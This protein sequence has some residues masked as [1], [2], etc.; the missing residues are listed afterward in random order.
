MIVAL[1]DIGQPERN[2]YMDRSA[3]VFKLHALISVAL[4][5]K[6][7]WAYLGWENMGHKL[8][9][10]VLGWGYMGLKM[11]IMELLIR[12]NLI[13]L[14]LIYFDWEV[15]SIPSIQ[16]KIQSVQFPIE[17]KAKIG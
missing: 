2:M 3:T 14:K 10:M 1:V 8:S 15:E 6:D 11:E 4:E 17:T 16:A 5:V 12:I 7:L 13:L 9:D